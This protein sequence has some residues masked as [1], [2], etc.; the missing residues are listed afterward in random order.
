MRNRSPALLFSIFS[1]IA[2]AQAA[3][4]NEVVLGP[5]VRASTPGESISW[6]WAYA[7]P[8]DGQHLIVCGSLS[9]PQL[10][11]MYGYVYSSPDAGAI[12]RR[13]L[14]DDFTKFVSEESCTYGENG[15]AYF[16]DGESDTSTG[17][18]RHEWGHTQLFTSADHGMSWKR[19]G[20]R[21]DGWL[22]W[23][24][25]AALPKDKELPES[26]VIFANSGTDKLG[27]WWEKRPVALEVTRGGQSY[28]ALVAPATSSFRNFGGGSVVLPDRTALFISGTTNQF[29]DT[30]DAQAELQ[31][32]AYSSSNR[33]LRARAVLRKMPPGRLPSLWPALARDTASGRFPNRLYASWAEFQA[34]GPAELWLATSDDNG[35][36]W[37]ARVILSLA[38][39]HRAACPNDPIAFSDVRIALNR[40]GVLGILRLQDAKEVL[41]AASSDGG[42]TFHSSELVASHATGDLSIEDALPYNEWWLAETL[43]A[44]E[45]KSPDKFLDAS[46]LGLSV[47]L[48]KPRG[49]GD[50]SL[51]ADAKN[52]FHA[53]WTGLDANGLHALMTRTIAAAASAHGTNT[54]L[55]DTAATA[56]CTERTE[57]LHPPLPS[58]PSSLSLGGQQDVTQSFDL[59]ITHIQFTPATH[60]VTADVVLVN[61]G[62]QIVRAPLSLFAVG[63]HSDYGVPVAVNASGVT[64]GQ[65]FWDLSSVI[66][67]EGLQPKASSKPL[68]LRFELEHFQSMPTGDAVAMLVRVYR[69]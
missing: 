63:L 21:A 9:Y 36:H 69:K 18:P 16:A 48:S 67:T 51:A 32:F 42:R 6:V 40:D 5:I 7:D 49:V 58:P 64:Q 39:S 11:V 2:C 3:A 29:K 65:F 14:L 57:P 50:F 59:Q 55:A 52:R 38:H 44:G 61:K 45:G 46:H 35:Y 8:T 62:D 30:S 54:L 34:K 37:S 56:S 26:L 10:N 13:T 66:P 53:V 20:N 28:S 22:D 60:A 68:E 41:F 47:R 23:T 31:I 27:H 4:P 33:T 19:A 24:L 12:W 15:G 43:A 25:L 1:S 17:E